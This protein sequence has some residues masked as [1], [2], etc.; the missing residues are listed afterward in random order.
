MKKTYLL[1]LS[2]FILTLLFL[3]PCLC[4]ADST[5]TLSCA[6]P[7]SIFE[8]NDNVSFTL[9]CTSEVHVQVTDY[10]GNTVYSAAHENGEI[11]IPDLNLGRFTI[12]ATDGNTTASTYFA[13]VPE[14]SQRRDSS[15]SDVAFSAMASHTYSSLNKEADYAKTIAL[16]GVPYVREFCNYNEIW[17]PEIS[18]GKRAA[19]LLDEYKKNNIGVLYMFQ[20]MPGSTASTDGHYIT[21]D[22]MEVYNTVTEL[23]RQHGDKI[24]AL[25]ILNEPDIASKTDSPDLYAAVLKAAS[26][27]LSDYE[28]DI[29]LSNAGFSSNSSY[30]NKFLQNEP[31]K[32]IDIYNTHFYLNYDENKSICEYPESLNTLSYSADSFA[33]TAKSLWISE[34]G[35]RIPYETENS[36]TGY[37]DLT[38]EQ[39]RQQ[40]RTAPTALIKAQAAGIDKAFWFIHGYIRENGK[41]YGTM[42]SFNTPHSVYSSIS[43]M[44]N[45]L[46]NSQYYGTFTNLPNG[47][48][49]Y[50]Y[51]EGK[52]EIGC[53]WA[54]DEAN[55]TIYPN[56]NTIIVTDIMGNETI[57]TDFDGQYTFTAGSD[58]IYVRSAEGFASHSVNIKEITEKESWRPSLNDAE[59]I[60]L[61]PQFTQASQQN[62]RI[63]GYKLSAQNPNTVAVR[64]YNFNDKEMTGTVSASVSG[65]WVVEAPIKRV[66]VAPMNYVETE[67]VI[68]GSEK[69]VGLREVPLVFSGNFNGEKTSDSVCSIATEDYINPDTTF[70]A[71]NWKLTTSLGNNTAVSKSLT[72]TNNAIKMTFDF[73]G[74]AQANRNGA[75]TTKSALNLSGSDGLVV[76][77][78][79]DYEFSTMSRLWI[80]DADGDLFYSHSPLNLDSYSTLALKLGDQW[81]QVAFCWNTL[82]DVNT[83]GNGI[84][85]L[86]SATPTL[87]IRPIEDISKFNI[88][89][90]NIGT[91]NNTTDYDEEI[92]LSEISYDDNSLASTFSTNNLK[93]VKHIIS[94]KIYNAEVNGKT[95][96]LN[97]V[98]PSGALKIYTFAFD[99]WN[100][101]YMFTSHLDINR[102]A[103]EYTV[104]FHANG[105]IEAPDGQLKTAGKSITLSEI[106]PTK[107]NASFAGWA[108]D[109]FA[110]EAEYFPGDI[111]STDE[112][113]ILYA[114][115]HNSSRLTYDER[116]LYTAEKH[117]IIKGYA[118]LS[119]A[120]KRG[121]V[122]VYNLCSTPDTLSP[123]DIAYINEIKIDADG[124]YIFDFP[125]NNIAENYAYIINVDG[126]TVSGTLTCT[127]YNYRWLDSVINITRT[128]SSITLNAIVKNHANSQL[129]YSIVFAAYDQSGKL[130]SANYEKLTTETESFSEAY[131]LTNDTATVK[132]FIWV[133]DNLIPLCL[134]V[135]KS[136]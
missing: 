25:E 109:P 43:A 17:N 34:F 52:E 107:T 92:V 60:V 61:L 129:N 57:V 58:I 91:F 71:N 13:I 35:L 106:T 63:D 97:T 69:V 66:T 88:Y 24:D 38:E 78:K 102:N 7:F 3:Q 79:S 86:S 135:I 30:I 98:L 8:G 132:A 83:T 76:E 53:F 2:T 108:T 23:C 118:G 1:K 46:G 48:S 10:F 80:Q 31:E 115:W 81:R 27:A 123:S 67:F 128:G 73:S 6:A 89:L 19:R 119:H 65:G 28:G 70:S 99:K 114:L 51:K 40:A 112:S 9:G 90:G 125:I 45:A 62:S 82:K 103:N 95:S 116:A 104:L 105:G 64:V 111:Y 122:V 75:C 74:V 15:N 59:R 110:Q 42:T 39:Q 77:Y 33:L 101:A 68:N 50:S 41:S 12:T 136:F 5:I 87:G 72:V 127:E 16:A 130:I 94:G 20:H 121:A 134:P 4:F 26:I 133:E 37:P 54:E 56:G 96:V 22:L 124:N 47:V 93:T 44:T 55:I 85:D 113:T 18:G 36:S 32:Y 29:R 21:N 49:G 131:S 117:M 120:G 126:E 84:L 100:R 14:L 11:N